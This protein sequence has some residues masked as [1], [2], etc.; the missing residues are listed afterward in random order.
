MYIICIP[1]FTSYIIAPTCT[2]VP[3]TSA[4]YTC[5]FMKYHEGYALSKCFSCSFVFLIGMLSKSR[6]QILRVAAV[7]HALFN[8]DTPLA[9]PDRISE[10]AIKAAKNFVELCNQHAAFLAGRGVI[11]DPLSHWC[12]SKEV[13]SR[14]IYTTV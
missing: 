4:P 10:A 8:L 3:C 5:I 7:M 9:I 14:V 1:L 2:S 6:G 13:R 11:S 12:S